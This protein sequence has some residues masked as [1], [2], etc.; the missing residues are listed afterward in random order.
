MA[1][2]MKTKTLNRKSK[3]ACVAILKSEAKPIHNEEYGL[4]MD[5]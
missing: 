2:E 1:K 3:R 5:E 4:K